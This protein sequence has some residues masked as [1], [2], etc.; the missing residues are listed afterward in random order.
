M[1]EQRQE[2]KKDKQLTINDN[3]F[4]QSVQVGDVCAL[5]FQVGNGYCLGEREVSLVDHIQHKDWSVFHGNAAPYGGLS[6]KA[7][8][9]TKRNKR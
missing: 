3:L 9:N 4:I 5:P 8:A 7:Y 1:D 2:E 6:W